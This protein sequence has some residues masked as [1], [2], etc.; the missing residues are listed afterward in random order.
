MENPKINAR[1]ILRSNS[2]LIGVFLARYFYVGNSISGSNYNCRYSRR[3]VFRVDYTNQSFGNGEKICPEIAS[4][5]G[6]IIFANDDAL[7]FEFNGTSFE[8]KIFRISIDMKQ[9]MPNWSDGQYHP[10][11]ARNFL[12][13]SISSFKIRVRLRTDKS[14]CNAIEGFYLFLAAILNFCCL[15]LKI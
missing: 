10:A 1:I 14:F 4:K 3:N 11:F 15:Y 6:K 5:F 8:A 7:G 2:I 12:C 13:A 9:R